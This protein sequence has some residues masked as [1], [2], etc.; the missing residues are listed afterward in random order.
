MF[1]LICLFVGG[2]AVFLFNS[3][4]KTERDR[5]YKA[6]ISNSSSKP[7]ADT[8]QMKQRLSILEVEN[9]T[10][11][12][13]IERQE[14]AERARLVEE[15]S[16]RADEEKR[17]REWVV[18]RE[19]RRQYTE[20]NDLS[21]AA[22]QLKFVMMTNLHLSKPVNREAAKYVLYALEEW[23]AVH[24][25]TWKLAFEVSMGSFIRT[26]I[27][28]EDAEKDRLN[29]AAFSSYNSKRVDFLFVDKFGFPKL[30]VEYRGTGSYLSPDAEARMEVKRAACM[31][32]GLPL[33]EIPEKPPKALIMSMLEQ[34]MI[35]PAQQVKAEQ[36]AE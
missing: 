35:A 26:D 12:K 34:T 31:K 1:S 14:I 16:R 5:V 36:D 22:N 25:P 15:A 30:V 33:L 3:R 24:Q 2:F 11:K 20:E 23:R 9:V 4:Q 6:L 32:V 10:L 21:D 13:K 7:A 8:E 19:R 27:E 17:A 29:R 28:N 18:E